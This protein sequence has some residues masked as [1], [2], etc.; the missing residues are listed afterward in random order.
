[1]LPLL[2]DPDDPDVELEL[3]DVFDVLLLLVLD[4]DVDVAGL[5][6][7]FGAVVLIL[8]SAE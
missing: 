1:M 8:T 7:V 2:L 5:A 6:A 4:V 3:P